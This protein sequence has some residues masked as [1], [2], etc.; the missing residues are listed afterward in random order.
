MGV[1]PCPY[2]KK[3]VEKLGEGSLGPS[4]KQLDFEESHHVQVHDMINSRVL[5]T[6]MYDL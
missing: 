2:P 4:V 1:P 3:N 5:D 6:G